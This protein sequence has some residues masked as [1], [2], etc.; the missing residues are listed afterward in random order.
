[1]LIAHNTGR[2]RAGQGPRSIRGRR[3]TDRL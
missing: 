1:M 3:R 2:D